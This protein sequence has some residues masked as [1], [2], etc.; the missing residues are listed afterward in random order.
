MVQ[1]LENYKPKEIEFALSE[2][3]KENFPAT[4]FDG[5]QSV[6]EVFKLVNDHFVAIYPDN[7]KAIRK[8]DAY[9]KA[10]TR[11]EY[12]SYTENEL[13]KRLEELEEAVLTAKNLKKNAEDRLEDI[14]RRIAELAAE[15]KRG[16]REVELPKSRTIRIALNGYYLFYAWVDGKFQ[17]CD[18]NRIPKWERNEL[19]A[20]DVQNIEAMQQLFGYSFPVPPKPA[21]ITSEAS[22]EEDENED[23]DND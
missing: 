10:E 14:R 5:A 21:E 16:V 15:V 6:D 13:P 3:L 4:L 20:Q 17:L 11:A 22:E 12:C 2:E 1:K 9:E 19:W 23:E 8:M 18:G 7:H